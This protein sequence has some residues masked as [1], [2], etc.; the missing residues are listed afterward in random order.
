MDD[1]D[2]AK[3]SSKGL[4]FHYKGKYNRTPSDGKEKILPQ[5]SLNF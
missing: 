1:P 5:G 4:N 2:V 3:A